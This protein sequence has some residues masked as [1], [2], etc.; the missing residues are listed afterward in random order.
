MSPE[1]EENGVLL[2]TTP[3]GLECRLFRGMIELWLDQET[4]AYIDNI[5]RGSENWARELQ[6]MKGNQQP[7]TSSLPSPFHFT[8]LTRIA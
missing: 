3:A 1:K 2:Q 6:A 5:G 4:A 7:P 8:P